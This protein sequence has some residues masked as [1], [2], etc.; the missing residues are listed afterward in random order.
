MELS[1]D[2]PPAGFGRVV[3]NTTKGPARVVEIIGEGV[4][5]GRYGG[6]VTVTRYLGTTP[7]AVDL[8]YGIH[9]LE[10]SST[11][12]E[13]EHDLVRYRFPSGE[14]HGYV[15]TLGHHEPRSAQEAAG[16]AFIGLGSALA[17]GAIAA[18]V[19]GGRD[20]GL[21]LGMPGALLLLI[22]I[23]VA[24]TARSVEQPGAATW[25]KIEP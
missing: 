14:T 25:W 18:G 2:P 20:W 11:A 23:P 10:L 8:P 9:E 24:A 3:I 22:G 17:L 7:V 6:P 5:H 13:H 19:M 1:D 21:G 4:V 15:R 12:D 16:A